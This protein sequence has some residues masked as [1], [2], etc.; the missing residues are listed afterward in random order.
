MIF[1]G[2]SAFFFANGAGD[3]RFKTQSWERAELSEAHFYNTPPHHLKHLDDKKGRPSYE[4][5]PNFYLE[6]WSTAFLIEAKGITIDET[7]YDVY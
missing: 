7:T 2:V 5:H 6:I 3:A 4:A 1:E